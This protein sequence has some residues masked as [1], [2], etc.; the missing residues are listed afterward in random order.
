[1]VFRALIA[2]VLE[3]G[4]WR[5]VAS[6]RSF[7]LRLGDQF[8][9]L[10][11]GTPPSTRYVDSAFPKVRHIH[12][13]RWSDEELAQVLQ[14]APT[15]ATA[16]KRGGDRLRDLARVPF[17]TRLLADLISGGLSAEAFGE[18]SHQVQLL[19]L[20]W[21]HRVEQ[22]GSGAELCLRAA[23]AQMAANRN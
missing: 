23:V 6:I 10:F 8:K 7:D 14:R 18:V 12:V 20:Y 13:P 22:Y 21:Q 5:V 11:A 15:L 1:A 16:V 17:N 19:A 3:I 9:T 2:E 4:R